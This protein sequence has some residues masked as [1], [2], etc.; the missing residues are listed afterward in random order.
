MLA[1][2]RQFAAA[3]AFHVCGWRADANVALADRAADRS[4]VWEE[5]ARRCR[6]WGEDA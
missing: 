5:R 2:L 3:V 6:K 4:E 1:S